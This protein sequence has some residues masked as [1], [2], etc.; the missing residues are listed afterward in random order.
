MIQKNIT[1][2]SAGERRFFSQRHAA[3]D[4]VTFS[5]TF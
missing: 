3:V 4:M 1:F 5:V 2:M